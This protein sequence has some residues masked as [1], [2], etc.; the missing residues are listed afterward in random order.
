MKTLPS[1]GRYEYSAITRRPRFEWPNKSRL[2]VYFALGVEHYA[3]GEGIT[4][5]LVSGMP[6]PDVLN[7]SWREYGNRVGAWRVLQL[8]F[9][10]IRDTA[11][12]SFKQRRLRACGRFD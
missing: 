11:Q 5:N 7:A 9:T 8:P 10:D 1:H 12:H 2:A 4:E 6:H 3:F